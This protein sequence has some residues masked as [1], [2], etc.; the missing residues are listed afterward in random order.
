MQPP[1]LSIE[2][3]GNRSEHRF[4]EIAHPQQKRPDLLIRP[5]KT[6]PLNPSLDQPAAATG[7]AGASA[8]FFFAIWRLRSTAFG[9]SSLSRALSK[10]ASR[11][12]R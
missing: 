11:P 2:G 3:I 10:N 8:S 6:L 1:E 4:W 5:S 7:A 12:P 9:D